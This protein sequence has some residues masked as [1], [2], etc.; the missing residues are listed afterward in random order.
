MKKRNNA[1]MRRFINLIASISVVLIVMIGF[2]TFLTFLVFG[3]SKKFMPNALS[4]LECF[5]IGHTFFAF[6]IAH[7]VLLMF[8]KMAISPNSSNDAAHI[9][10][11]TS[12]SEK[13]DLLLSDI[14]NRLATF[15]R[16]AITPDMK[17]FI[18]WKDFITS[19]VPIIFAILFGFLAFAK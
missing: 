7:Q 6:V 17:G 2:D 9:A 4:W 1:T 11:S 10:I 3:I 16:T 14:R 5:F 12:G 8:I 19:C 18:T 15:D 13:T